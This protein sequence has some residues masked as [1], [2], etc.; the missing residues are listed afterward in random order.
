MARDLESKTAKDELK[1]TFGWQGISYS[2][3][4]KSGK[5]DILRNV[6]GFL[7]SGIFM[8]ETGLI[9]G[10]MLAVMG[11]SGCGNTTL[12]NILSRR[13]KGPNVE[14]QQFFNHSIVDDTTMRVMSTYVEQEDHLTGSLTVA[15]TIDFAAKL[16]LPRSV[17]SAERRKRTADLLRSFGLVPV[18]N[19]YIGTPFKRGIS[20]G[21]KRRVTTASQLVT[22]PKIMFLGFQ[23]AILKEAHVRRTYLRIGQCKRP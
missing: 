14:G 21:H 17:S 9:V 18:E 20:G 16:A 3:R 2:V 11:P 13:L 1:V 6:G 15:E 8:S 10:E 4:T 23:L 22:L 12:L 7:K 5:K 19:S